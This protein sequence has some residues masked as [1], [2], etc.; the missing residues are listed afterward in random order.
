MVGFIINLKLMIWVGAQHSET[1]R[2]WHEKQR[3]NSTPVTANGSKT[4]SSFE[5][6]GN[7]SIYIFK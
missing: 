3:K 2:G 6:V 1:F 4:S 7:N 5:E